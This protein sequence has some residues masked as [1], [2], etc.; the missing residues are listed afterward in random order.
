MYEAQYLLG[1]DDVFTPWLD[2]QADNMAFAAELIAHNGTDTELEIFPYTKP[3]NVPGPGTAMSL[4]RLSIEDDGFATTIWSGF[5]EL[6]RFRIKNG[7]T[8][9]SDSDYLLFRLLP[10]A[11]F[12]SVSA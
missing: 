11:W 6:V 12:D 8:S 5:N 2:R 9:P 1:D 3:A 7:K 4:P 10:I